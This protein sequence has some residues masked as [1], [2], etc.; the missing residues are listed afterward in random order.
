MSV[1][2][3]IVVPVFNAMDYLEDCVQCI[4]CGNY[5]NFEILLIDDG[6]SDGTAELCDL[7]QRKHAE[8]R[9][10]HTENRGVP[11]ARN[12]G[13]ENASGQYIG[14]VDADDL[15][16]PNMF[17]VLVC[18]MT[19]DTQLTA[20]RFQRCLR[21]SSPVFDEEPLQC[22]TTDQ[23]G[24]AER[25]ICGSYGPYVW[26][27]LYRKD[28]L[29]THNIRFLPDSQGAEDQFFNAAYL[30]YCAKAVFL[31][32]KM[33]CY[34]I[35]DG[36]ITSTFRT[37]RIV[38]NCYVSLPRS[39]RFTAEVMTDIS[40]NL[41]IWSEARA[42]MFYQTVLR[43]LEKPDSDYIEEAVTYVKR[44]K[45]TLLRYRWGFKYYISGLVL[46]VSYPLWAKIFRR[47]LTA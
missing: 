46:S 4:T 10:F 39:W 34:V 30:K 17:E 7:L 14:F 20:C 5:R 19:P 6:S 16:S 21:N 32:Q 15:I 29:D 35:N 43:K 44:N 9:V 41:K 38:S 31:N 24:A 25:I 37:S 45:S 42:T 1:I 23:I 12:L 26:N 22:T 36:S 40:V 3:S 27:K 18:S 2:L 13:I 11:S 28:I 47:G 33:Y 8:I